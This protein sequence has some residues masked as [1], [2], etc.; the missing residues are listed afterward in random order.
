MKTKT[1]D[2]ISDQGNRYGQFVQYVAALMPNVT[3][4]G[5]KDSREVIK[6]KRVHKGGVLIL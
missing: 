4:F 3:V 2:S 5:D 1:L 6:V